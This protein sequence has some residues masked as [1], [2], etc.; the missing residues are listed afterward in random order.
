MNLQEKKSP[1][2]WLPKRL[3]D[4]WTYVDHISNDF[5]GLKLIQYLSIKYSH[6]SSEEWK[7]RI[8][9]GQVKINDLATHQ[10]RRVYKKDKI[11]WAR[12]AWEEPSVPYKW[13]IIFDN[14]DLLVINK[15]S[16]L[17]VIPGGGFLKH[18]L[19]ELLKSSSNLSNGSSYPK[20]IHRLGRFTS[21][22]LVCARTKETRAKISAIFRNEL[23]I[24]SNFNRVYRGL[25]QKNPKLSYK[26]NCYI[27]YPIVQQ[28]HSNLGFVWTHSKN[29]LQEKSSNNN[30]YK[31][32]KAISEVKLLEERN[33]ADLLEIKIRTGRPHQ[34]RIHLASIGSPLIG[35]P[36]YKANGNIT[37]NSRPGEGGFLLHSH[38]LENLILNE[39]NYSFE[40]DLPEELQLKR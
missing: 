2:D 26:K 33:N 34:I 13:R 35:D 23:Q 9:L 11:S 19:S 20:P 28:K 1:S 40:A 3:N 6:S 5:H 24:N 18:T 15:P 32:L 10:N 17:P 21:G 27:K 29:L 14:D 37:E 31:S 22:V 7:E 38:R 36:L 4:G 8:I 39:T 25:S 12:N 30:Q 16:G